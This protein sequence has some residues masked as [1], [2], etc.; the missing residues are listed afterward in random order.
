[1]S[2][3]RVSPPA[4]VLLSRSRWGGLLLA[5]V[6]VGLLY[7]V[8]LTPDPRPGTFRYPSHRYH[9]LQAEAWLEGR[10]DLPLPVPAEFARLPDPYDPKSSEP[11]RMAGE[12]GIHDLSF[13]GGKLYLYW[14]PVPALTAFLPWR[15]LTGRALDSSWAGWAFAMGAW[16][17][18][19]ILVVRLVGR[20]WPGTS[21]VVLLLCLLSLG[22]CSWAP[23][24]LRRSTVWEIPIL[25]A[26]CYGVLMF[27]LMAECVWSKPRWR[28][29][30]LAAASLAL[31]LAVGSRPIWIV[32]SPC[33]LWPLWLWRAEWRQ[34]GF[35]SLAAAAVV[36]VSLA[37][38]GLLLLNQ[39]RF[40]HFLEFG[41]QW[42]VAG[43]R[44]NGSRTFALGQVP[45]NLC[46][47]LFS[48]PG[49]IDY[50]PF[51]T[52]PR[53]GEPPAGYLGLENTFGL[54]IVLPW[55]WCAAFTAFRRDRAA[56]VPVVAWG[57]VSMFGILCLFNGA[58]GRYQF[59]MAAPFALLA[60]CGALQLMAWSAPPAPWRLAGLALLLGA[61]SLGAILMS[62]QFGAAVTLRFDGAPR[63]ET[64]ANRVA[65]WLG[66]CPADAIEAVELTVDFSPQPG[67]QPTGSGAL[68]AS[69]TYPLNN[70]V[71][72]GY[73]SE[74]KVLFQAFRSFTIQ[75]VVEVIMDRSVPH[76]VRIELGAL[77]PPDRHPFWDGVP[78][79]A[80]R[81][82]RKRV[83]ILCDGV[84]I[85]QGE[86]DDFPPGSAL[87]QI[88][89]LRDASGKLTN[90]FAGRI[91]DVKFIR[92]AVP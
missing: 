30:W 62:A 35:W 85:L 44:M 51:V 68:L 42:Q 87:P 43:V 10:L 36:P 23:V 32:C 90:P 20:Q 70:S 88:G 5:A 27:T 74:N 65:T 57:G 39:L 63:I 9:A 18:A 59:E 24:V 45:Y 83:R 8:C 89:S 80:I 22:I 14:G 29:C 15:V 17:A 31:G 78:S 60:A 72:V 12:N 66:W 50:F 73:P 21:P 33:L 19:A 47:Y 3:V 7:G 52:D 71:G 26:T 58:A 28:W 76:R 56:V 55:L 13:R 61:S 54:L 37:V 41:Q 81:H 64:V 69:G 34:R 77:L 25:A 79:F 2:G 67:P 1:M 38:G 11:F 91:L 86:I 49:L 46:Q 53:R 84:V 6:C 40:G 82:R 48:R 16:L 4:P 92:E 75:Q